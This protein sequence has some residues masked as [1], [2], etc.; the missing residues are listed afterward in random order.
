M[1]NV[2]P[3]D[4]INTNTTSTNNTNN[5]DNENDNDNDN[6]SQELL[7]D[8]NTNENESNNLL[9]ENKTK[10]KS[11]KQN[12]ISITDK[13]VI[14]EKVED[15]IICFSR[16]RK[17]P[18]K[19]EDLTGY[20]ITFG[21]FVFFTILMTICLSLAKKIPDFSEVLKTLYS[22]IIAFIWITSIVCL[23]CLTDAAF[24]DPGRQRGTPIPKNKYEK[25]K[26]KKIVGGQKYSLKYCYTCHLIRDIRTFHCSICGLCIEKHDHHCNYLSNCVGVYNYKK[27][28]I[29][30]VMAFIHVSIIFF[31]SCHFILFCQDDNIKGYEWITLLITVIIVFAGFFE[32]FTGWMLIQHIINIVQNRTTREFIKKKEYGIYNKGCRENCKEALCSNSIKEL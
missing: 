18:K 23:I 8:L 21:F 11:S 15:R 16:R 20:L 27:F 30:V 24:A 6:R 26:I 25:A 19:I 12:E 3:L 13:E 31:T 17:M 29:F 28:F 14:Q 2:I 10:N 22:W 4:S 32:I 1:F 5:N 7:L 9:P